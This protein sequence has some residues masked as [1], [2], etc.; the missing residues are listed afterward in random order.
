MLHFLVFIYFIL[1][2]IR[3]SDWVPGLVGTPLVLVTGVISIL[4]I[5]FG[6]VA[7][8]FPSVLSGRTERM[9]F[10]FLA[11][12]AL[13]H[14]SHFYIGGAIDSLNSFLPTITGFFLV[15]SFVDS[16]KRMNI[17]FILLLLLTAFL[18]YEGWLQ[19]L[20]G[21]AHGGIEPYYEKNMTV[22]GIIRVSRIRWYGMFNDPNDLG[23]ALVLAIP[24]LLNVLLQRRYLVPLTLLPLLSGAIYFTN[25]RGTLLAGL[26][27]IISYFI[28]RYRSAKGAVYGGMIAFVLFLFGPSRIASIS[29]E[30]DSA[31]GRIQAWYQAYQMFKSNPLFGVGKGMFTD[32]HIIVAHNSFVHVMAELGFIGLFFF[33]GLFY[34]PFNWL[35]KN[36]LQPKDVI[37]SQD[38]IGVISSCFASLT[39]IMAAMFFISRSYMLIPFMLVGLTSSVTRVID[40]K[41]S[42][43]MILEGK[44]LVHIRNILVLTCL[45]ILAINILVKLTI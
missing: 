3:P 43:G 2:Y 20:T 40:N 35:W 21:F 1:F 23:M 19:H 9:M 12:I 31:Y 7:G 32:F 42:L 24:F 17:F 29:A 13:S 16:Q 11:A 4:F 27:S 45:Q 30:E 10:G 34:F 22:D 37:F 44:P 36:M 8:R 18:A 25:S 28:F 39:G 38:D 15:I 14:L 5:V 6:A 41:Y 26:V 33:T